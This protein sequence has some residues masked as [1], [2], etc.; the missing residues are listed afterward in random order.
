MTK[1]SINSSLDYDL[2]R[3]KDKTINLETEI[4]RLRDHINTYENDNSN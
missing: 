2:K 4:T 3:S 1:S